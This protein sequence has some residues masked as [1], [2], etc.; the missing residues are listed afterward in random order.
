M[1]N[2]FIDI[3]VAQLKDTDEDKPFDYFEELISDVF[4]NDKSAILQHQMT[5]VL[6]L[7]GRRYQELH[8]GSRRVFEKVIDFLTEP[9]DSVEDEDDESSVKVNLRQHLE[10][11]GLESLSPDVHRSYD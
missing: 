8:G 10:G 1:Y 2:N 11:K 6:E 4:E 7:V 3:Q 9:T 5:S